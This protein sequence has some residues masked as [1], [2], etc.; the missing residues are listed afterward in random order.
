MSSFL[1]T[2]SGKFSQSLILG[3]FFPVS[4]FTL[5]ALMMVPPLLSAPFGDFVLADSLES[6][7]YLLLITMI[8]VVLSGLLYNLNIPLIRIYE[9][10]P[11]Y[12]SWLGKRRVAHYQQKFRATK[13]RSSGLRALYHAISSNQYSEEREKIRIQR[14]EKTRQ[15]FNDFPNEEGWVLPTR[16]GNAI[17]NFENYPNRQ[18]GMRAITLWPRLLAKIDSSYASSID[19][20]KSTFDFMLNCSALSMLLAFII[21]TAGLAYPVQLQ[22]GLGLFLWI[23]EII[24]LIMLSYLFYEWSIGTAITWG[25]LV[26]GAFDLYRWDLLKQMGY[27]QTPTNK[28]D[29]RKVW[30]EI[31]YEMAFSDS[32]KGPRIDYE[33]E[34]KPAKT[35]AQGKIKSGQGEPETTTLLVSRGMS[36]P[37]S[38][39]IFPIHI[40]IS[41]PSDKPVSEV[42]LTDTLPEGFAYDWNSATCNGQQVHAEGINPYQFSLGDIAPN[43]RVILTYRMIQYQVP[44]TTP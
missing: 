42:M 23:V 12:K 34:G 43:T 35:R 24:I 25:D 44:E 28:T 16:L 38:S 29:E 37:V 2:V 7:W 30:Q 21:L 19:S 6:P 41:N 31:Y 27:A 14:V 18:Y 3:T 32:S 5:L 39:G 9:G 40:Q 13:A 1:T 36:P 10:Y 17:R 33:A 11:W 4:V 22:E 8:V 26:K 20:A 15:L